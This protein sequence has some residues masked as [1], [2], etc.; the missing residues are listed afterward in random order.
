M[1][2]RIDRAE[3]L[4]LVQQRQAQLAEV[5]PRGEYDEEHLA[6]AVHLPLKALDADAAAMLDRMRPV[7][8]YCWDGL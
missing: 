7:V 6:D 5:L 2:T 8:V 4:R 3:V 1:V